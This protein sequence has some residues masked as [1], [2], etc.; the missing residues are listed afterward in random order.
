MLLRMSLFH[1]LTIIH[2]LKVYIRVGLYKMTND[3]LHIDILF[4]SALKDIYRELFKI[5]GW[6]IEFR[7]T[8]T[9]Y[10]YV[11]IIKNNVQMI[12]R[13][14]SVIRTILQCVIHEVNKEAYL[15]LFS[16]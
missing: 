10:T 7:N 2:G 11:G 13:Y 16:L 9:I 4:I 14:I 15:N 1:T 12:F 3:M 5:L 8:Y 6:S